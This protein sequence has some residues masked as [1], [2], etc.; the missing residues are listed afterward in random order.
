MRGITGVGVMKP[1]TSAFFPAKRNHCLPPAFHHHLWIR[2]FCL[3][4]QGQHSNVI[5]QGPQKR[6]PDSR[7]KWR[8]HILYLFL[9]VAWQSVSRNAVSNSKGHS[10]TAGPCME[11]KHHKYTSYVF[12]LN[13]LNMQPERNWIKLVSCVPY[14]LCLWDSN[15]NANRAWDHIHYSMISVLSFFPPTFCRECWSSFIVWMFTLQTAVH[16]VLCQ[17]LQIKH[18]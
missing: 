9:S 12:R 16:S 5:F 6:P 17:R 11:N 8:Y 10:C 18:S 7:D 2:P 3:R 13:I 15:F 1:L 14:H 4:A